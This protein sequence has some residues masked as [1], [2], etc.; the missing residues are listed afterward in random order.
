MPGA[1]SIDPVKAAVAFNL[2]EAGYAKNDIA[3]RT[4]ISEASVRDILAK[5]GRWGEVAERPVFARLRADQNLHLEAAFRAGS[6]VLL[7]RAFEES[8]LKKASTFQLVI[9]ASTALDKS[10]LLAGESTSNIAIAHHVEVQ[11]LN[12]AADRIAHSLLRFSGGLAVDITPTE[13]DNPKV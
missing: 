5:H 7:A 1:R 8:K 10:R 13:S 9:A 2:F 3:R 6:A 11:D 4:G 12:I